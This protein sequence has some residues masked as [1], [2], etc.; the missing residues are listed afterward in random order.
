[1]GAAGQRRGAVADRGR[2]ALPAAGA[3]LRLAADRLARADQLRAVRLPPAREAALP[4]R[5]R[6]PPADRPAA[7]PDPL[8][9]RAAAG[10]GA[11]DRYR[12]RLVL[13]FRAPVPA[14]Q[15]AVRD[16]PLASRLSRYA[17]LACPESS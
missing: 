1:A 17:R 8:D 14:P 6:E 5:D 11:H 13:R 7:L 3:G 15:G 12:G 4:V 9:R 16:H 2:A 10:A